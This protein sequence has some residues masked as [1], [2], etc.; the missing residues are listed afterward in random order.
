MQPS[1]FEIIEVV[2]MDRVKFTV[3]AIQHN[4]TKRI[5]V[6]STTKGIAQRYTAHLCELSRG[7]HRSAI[8]QLDYNEFGNDYS[9]F[10]LEQGA[11]ERVEH[12]YRFGDSIS[13]RT[14]AEYQWMKKYNTIDPRFGYN[15]QDKSAKKYIDWMRSYEKLGVKIEQ[16]LPIGLWNE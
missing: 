2:T 14:M 16:G 1:Q 5:Y 8:M 7:K 10:V 3:Y 12:P 4:Q 6:G 9:L 13:T 11:T 15:A